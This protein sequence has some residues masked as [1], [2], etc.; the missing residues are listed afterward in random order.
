MTPTKILP[1]LTLLSLTTLQA[2]PIGQLGI[3]QDTANGG[4]NPQTGLA[5]AD[6]D[7]YR[8]AFVSS[9]TRDAVSTDIAD[10]NQF[11][12]DT[13]NASSLGLS[14]AT[15]K[16]I[17]ST[18]TVSAPANTGTDLGLN[19]PIYL[20]DGETF[21]STNL[22]SGS[23]IAGI[24]LDEEL[25]STTGVSVYAGTT[26]GGDIV[27]N[28]YLGTIIPSKAGNTQVVVEHGRSGDTGGQ[29]IRVFNQNPTV[30]MP[31]YILSEPLT[32]TI[33]A[34]PTNT[35]EITTCDYDPTTD[36]ITLT[37]NSTPGATYRF[38]HSADLQAWSAPIGTPV[39][40]DP[41]T[42]TSTTLNLTTLG[43]TP[44]SQ[45]FFRIEQD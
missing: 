21:V 44:A 36:S 25:T 11:A 14:A 13:A 37:W 4:F 18:E 26:P 33:G 41:G 2:D 45:R 34:P 31:F 10:Y 19:L 1:L 29:W 30:A 27:A 24:D 12:Q 15:W 6:G 5:W 8:L 16:V 43:L 9:T 40:G 28:R 42:T 35:I 22:W 23:L 38:T 17:A 3:L 7:Q 32:V 20:L 39:T